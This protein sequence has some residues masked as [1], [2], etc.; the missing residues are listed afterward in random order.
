MSYLCL[1]HELE[2]TVFL[3][4]FKYLYCCGRIQSIPRTKYFSCII[5][6]T[7]KLYTLWIQIQNTSEILVYSLFQDFLSQS[8]PCTH[9]PDLFPSEGLNA[10]VLPTDHM[11]LVFKSSRWLIGDCVI[12][13][14]CALLYLKFLLMDTAC[15][16]H[17]FF[18]GCFV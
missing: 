4:L 8:C 6:G 11:N 15:L 16:G 14:I 17:F 3:E 9:S 18:S 5:S 10:G 7:S 13:F 12:L 2:T 1:Y